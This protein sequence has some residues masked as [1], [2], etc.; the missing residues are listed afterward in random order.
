MVCEGPR[1]TD[2]SGISRSAQHDVRALV[3]GFTC[4]LRKHS[5]VANDK[6]QAASIGP[7]TNR[8]SEVS[9]F[10]GLD[11]NPRMHLSIIEPYVTGIIDNDTAVV[12]VAI[13]IALHDGET[14][15]DVLLLAGL[16]E[17]SHLFTVQIAHD[18]RIGVHGKTMKAVFRKHD[19]IHRGHVCA[20]LL[21]HLA[22]TLR[23]SGQ[24]TLRLHDGELEL[25]QI[26]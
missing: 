11:G 17:S 9:R 2:G 23:L 22:H 20:S 4:H 15:P 21:H 16:P 5:V 13:G 8:Y 7:V 12:G 6:G 3:G 1:L 19:E 25:H 14:A 26:R 10:P 18:F 24:V